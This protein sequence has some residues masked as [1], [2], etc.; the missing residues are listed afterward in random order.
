MQAG[1]ATE[2]TK[3]VSHVRAQQQRKVNIPLIIYY[4]LIGIVLL[5]CIILIV[6]IHRYIQN[7]V[8]DNIILLHYHY[9]I[10]LFNLYISNTDFI[11]IVQVTC[12]FVTGM[13]LY[14]LI[15]DHEVE[16]RY[17]NYV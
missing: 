10:K 16:P 1:I 13:V 4:V 2:N 9:F 7:T 6:L 14:K 5:L 15:F 11:P 3:S 17:N 8:D 12:F